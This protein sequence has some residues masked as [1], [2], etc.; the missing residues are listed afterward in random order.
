MPFAYVDGMTSF[1]AII[2]QWP[3]V[4]SFAAAVGTLERTA[5]SWWQRDSI[6]SDWMAATVRAAQMAGKPL[7]TAER[8]IVLAEVRRLRKEAVRDTD[9]ALGRQAP[10]PG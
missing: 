1:R 5:M 7:I 8:L 2:E 4:A 9:G 3:T 6:P 10:D